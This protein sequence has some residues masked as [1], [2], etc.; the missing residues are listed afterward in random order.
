VTATPAELFDLTG[1]TALVTGASSGL[2]VEFAGTLRAAGATVILAARRKDRL[3]ELCAGAPGMDYVVCDVAD[4]SSV[5][6]AVATVVERHRQIDI[7]VNNAGTTW[8]G[9]AESEPIE[10]FRSVVEVNL[11]GHFHMAQAVGRH[12]LE[13]GS[14]SIINIASIHGLVAAAPNHQTSYAASK[15]GVVNLTR[16]LGVQWAKRGVR[17]NGIAPG[18]FSSELTDEFLKAE[19]GRQYV[20]RNTAIG[21]PG[22]GQELAGALL[23]L[24]SRAGSYIAGEV[25]VVDGG[26][27]AK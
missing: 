19:R 13:R 26:W 23:L 4:D 5:E 2:G 27:T 15:G 14:G 22:L 16:E 6:S 9:P 8:S 10:G 25:I 17:V 11:V 1:Q 3:V 24:A 7:L 21:R 20:T 18:Y 12:M